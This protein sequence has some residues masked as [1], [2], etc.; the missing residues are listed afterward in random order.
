MAACGSG[1]FVRIVVLASLF[2]TGP[3]LGFTVDMVPVTVHISA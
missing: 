2:P 1:F 3:V